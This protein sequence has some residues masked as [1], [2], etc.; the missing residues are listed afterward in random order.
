MVLSC[1]AV[2]CLPTIA[3]MITGNRPDGSGTSR[4]MRSRF[5]PARPPAYQTN[6]GEQARMARKAA[7]AMRTTFNRDS[8]LW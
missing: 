6:A 5:A 3:V 2:Q 7:D 8:S 1:S 4:S